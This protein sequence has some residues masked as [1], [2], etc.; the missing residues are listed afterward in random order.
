MTAQ[1]EEWVQVGWCDVDTRIYTLSLQL[2]EK[3]LVLCFLTFRIIINRCKEC[4][5]FLQRHYHNNNGKNLK[6]YQ[7]RSHRVQPSLRYVC[8]IPEGWFGRTDRGLEGSVNRTP[9]CL[10]SCSLGRA[11]NIKKGDWVTNDH[12]KRH[13]SLRQLNTELQI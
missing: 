9:H 1:K 5:I 6:T 4:Q 3:Y 2:L 12:N 10:Y 7:E 11:A 8:T 13:V